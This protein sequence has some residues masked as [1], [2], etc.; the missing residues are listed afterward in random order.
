MLLPPSLQVLQFER[1]SLAP[2]TIVLNLHYLGYSTADVPVLGLLDR[3]PN[4]KI[5]TRIAFQSSVF[6]VC[7]PTGV[8]TDVW[9]M[10]R[11]NI[12]FLRP[13]LTSLLP[14]LEPLRFCPWCKKA[15]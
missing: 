4:N 8:Q 2:G 11:D 5:K 15:S 9:G 10:V 14:L 1:Y 6:V 13:N 7:A 3:M 12:T